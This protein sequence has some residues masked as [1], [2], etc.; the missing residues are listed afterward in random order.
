MQ[1]ANGKKKLG[2]KK[3]YLNKYKNSE[4]NPVNTNGD[5]D[6]SEPVRGLPQR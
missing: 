6:M 4:P 1:Q 3:A 5:K 2:D